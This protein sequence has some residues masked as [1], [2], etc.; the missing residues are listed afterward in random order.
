MCGV[1]EGIVLRVDDEK[2]NHLLIIVIIFSVCFCYK[3]S[4]VHK[5]KKNIEETKSPIL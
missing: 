3:L 2:P 1:L 5:T 4:T